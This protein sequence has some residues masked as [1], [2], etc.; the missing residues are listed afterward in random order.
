MLLKVNQVAFGLCAGVLGATSQRMGVWTQGCSLPKCPDCVS[1]HTW[2]QS[3]GKRVPV[4]GLLR[5]ARR[6][7]V[8]PLGLTISGGEPTDQPAA[9][10]ELARGFRAGFPGSEIVLYSGLRWPVLRARHP[11]LVE[12][13]D[14]VVAGPYVRTLAATPLAGSGN[15]E[16]KLLTPLARE[17]YRD[18]RSWPLHVVQVASRADARLVS[19]GIPET[20]RLTRAAS[21]A[22]VIAESWEDEYVTRDQEHGE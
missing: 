5:L 16:V 18:W 19:I 7:S 10:A 22:G 15:Q 20:A 1:R 11:E 17:L 4:E 3:A 6:Q 12:L 21:Q 2:S 8:R 9:V 14:V 13:L